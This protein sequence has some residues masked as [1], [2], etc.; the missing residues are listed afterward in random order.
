MD[1][2]TAPTDRLHI[3]PVQ[4]IALPP[5]DSTAEPF[6]IEEWFGVSLSSMVLKGWSCINFFLFETA[7]AFGTIRRVGST[8]EHEATVYLHPTATDNWPNRYAYL[9]FLPLLFRVRFPMPRLF[10]NLTSPLR[11][12][13]LPPSNRGRQRTNQRTFH[14]SQTCPICSHCRCR[15]KLVVAASTNFVMGEATWENKRGC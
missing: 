3:F 14:Q 11:D 4:S 9:I 6:H 1:V 8:E 7:P 13:R 10:S 15:R 2:R 5:L 12:S